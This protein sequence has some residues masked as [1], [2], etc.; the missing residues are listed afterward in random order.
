MLASASL[1][2]AALSAPDSRPHI[3]YMLA[4]NIGYGGIGFQRARTPAGPSPEVVTPHLDKLA[5]DGVLL[6]RLYTYEFCSP[7]RSSLLSGRLPQHVNI[8]NDDQ[9]KPGA[10]IPPERATMS[11]KLREAGYRTHQLGKWQCVRSLEPT[12]KR[13]LLTHRLTRDFFV[14]RL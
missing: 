11:S 6:E 10:G 7:S 3:I 1:L 2:L 4:D 12:P 14:A 9:T 8:H 5:A 13:A